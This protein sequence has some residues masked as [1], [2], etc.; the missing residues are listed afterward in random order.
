MK[1]YLL[2]FSLFVIWSCDVDRPTSISN[3]Q[4]IK[5]I[6][7]KF[8]SHQSDTQEKDQRTIAVANFLP[9]GELDELTQHMTYPYTFEDPQKINIW[10]S[11]SPENIG[12]IMDGMDLDVA[13]HHFIYGADWPAEYVKAAGKS[14]PNFKRTET[15][16]DVEMQKDSRGYPLHLSFKD[17]KYFGETR[18]FHELFEY[19]QNGH[20][21][22][23]SHYVEVDYSSYP[24]EFKKSL[25]I[26]DGV[27]KVN[28]T[29]YRFQYSQN[30]LINL[31]KHFE[32][33]THQYTFNYNQKD[34]VESAFLINGKQYHHR[35]YYYNESGL[36]DRTEIYNSLG[37]LEYEIFYTY[38]YY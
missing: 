4:S 6:T 29:E 14:H 23:Y 36:S 35:K 15:E 20:V 10:G 22:N 21:N 27:S 28:Q 7:T 19:D 37:E 18:A 12:M 5:S 9:N 30:D 33:K 26:S 3:D 13:A 17:G 8:I 11:T 16:M 1:R 25:N 34:V 31:V 32:G 38:E 24:E 2:V